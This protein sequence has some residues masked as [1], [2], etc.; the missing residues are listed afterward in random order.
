[1]RVRVIL[2]P[3]DTYTVKVTYPKR[4]DSSVEVTHFEQSD[5]YNDQLARVLLSLDQVI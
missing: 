1:M 2:D 3:S 5:V 4:G